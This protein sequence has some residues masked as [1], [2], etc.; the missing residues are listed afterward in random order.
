M[1]VAVGKSQRYGCFFGLGDVVAAYGGTGKFLEC[2][3]Q[4]CGHCLGVRYTCTAFIVKR[5]TSPLGRLNFSA[6]QVYLRSGRGC[7]GVH[8]KYEI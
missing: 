8:N 7:R 3:V 6:L 4:K 5:R 1:S 2:V